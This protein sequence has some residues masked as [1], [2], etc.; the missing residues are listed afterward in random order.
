MVVINKPSKEFNGMVGHYFYPCS[1]ADISSDVSN[2]IRLGIIVS[3]V[4]SIS[5]CVTSRPSPD[6]LA[7]ALDK[8]LRL[9]AGALAGD[10]MP[11]ARRDCLPVVAIYRAATGR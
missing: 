11:A 5:A 2:G 1:I 6:A 3:I 7:D 10:D 8:P 4:L 9:C